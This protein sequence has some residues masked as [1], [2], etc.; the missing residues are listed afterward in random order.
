MKKLFQWIF[1]LSSFSLA[2]QNDSLFSVYLIGDAGEHREPG[3]ALLLLRKQLLSDTNSAV[4]FLGDN[5]Y[6]H[7]LI[8]NDP[9]SASHLES[10]LQILKEYKGAAYFIPGNHDWKAQRFNGLKTLKNQE[11]YVT[12]YLKKN[13]SV[14]NRDSGTFLPSGGLPGPHS[15]LIAEKLRLIIIDTQW[16]LHFY[17]KNKT[18]SIRETKKIFYSRLDSLLL[19]SKIAGERVLIAAHHPL[20]SNG[21]HSRSMQPYR[22]MVNYTPFRL[23]GFFGLT[24]L[25]TQDLAQPRYK[26][27]GVDLLKVIDKYSNVIY[28]S[29][30]EH[31]L[32]LIEHANNT[33]VISGSGSKVSSFV[34]KKKWKT[35]FE[36]DRSTGFV[37]IDYRP[38]QMPVITFYRTEG[39]DPVFIK[40]REK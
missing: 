32:Q 27:M 31:N 3:K 40:M 39:S 1:I 7:G 4:V 33:F 38:R 25:Y 20:F 11:D 15:V 17:K 18:G 14:S 26:K 22:F 19:A 12:D 24:R 21:L 6:P 30:H 36:D 13:S 2:A 23:F 8:K 9:V 29:G 37:K 16:F 10:Q 35:L 28:A 34:K 5:V